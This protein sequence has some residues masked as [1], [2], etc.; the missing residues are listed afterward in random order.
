MIRPDYIVQVCDSDDTQLAAEHCT[1]TVMRKKGNLMA[2]ATFVTTCSPCCPSF[3]LPF[4][5]PLMAR[6]ILDPKF[7]KNDWPGLEGG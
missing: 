5:S 4:L 7:D 3:G 1:Q 2:I 6:E